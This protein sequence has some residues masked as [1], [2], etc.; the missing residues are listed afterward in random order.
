MYKNKILLLI[1]IIILPLHFL[2]SQNNTNSPYTRF[3]YGNI[4]EFTSGAQRAM[5]GTGLALRNKSIINNLNPAS[6]SSVDSMTF[7]FDFGGSAQQ[8]RFSDNNGFAKTWNGNIEY[9]SLQLP[10]FKNVGFSA[11]LLPY[12]VSGYNFSTKDTIIT[13]PKLLPGQISTNDTTIVKSSYQGNGGISQVYSGL[14]VLL[15]NHLSLGMNA[16]FMYGKII[17]SSALSLSTTSSHAS[18][19]QQSITAKNFRFRFGAQYFNTF[20]DKHSVSVGAIYENKTS[21]HGILT[22]SSVSNIAGDTITQTGGFELP[23]M[24]GLGL[25]YNYNSKLTLSLDYTLQQW[26]KAMFF[27]KTDS[28]TNRSKIAFG[29]EYTPNFK[30]RKYLEKVRYRAGISISDSYYRINGLTPPQNLTLSLGFGFPLR[31][32]KS[33]V[34]TTFEYGKMGSVNLLQEDYFKFTVNIVSNEFW[35]MKHKL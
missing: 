31:N 33:I 25:N 27:Y 23:Q 21:L 30:S 26:S 5:G 20:A 35:F 8:S 13:V 15:F 29:A 7:M 34:N 11:G 24:F 18:Y 32:T 3:G 9:I 2:A 17:N 16:Y 28:L 22:N 1:L 10:L 19:Q 12:S 6:Y 4:S 14:S